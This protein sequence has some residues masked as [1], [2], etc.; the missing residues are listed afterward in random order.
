[1]PWDAILK[2]WQDEKPKPSV[3]AIKS[4][5]FDRDNDNENR[6]MLLK[7]LKIILDDTSP[8]CGMSDWLSTVLAAGEA[9]GQEGC[10][11]V[12]QWSQGS[13]KYKPREMRNIRRRS[14]L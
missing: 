13:S 3:T 10:D 2:S 9:L 1:V 4:Y 8:D 6:L 11:M 14:G 12:D 7:A 5:D